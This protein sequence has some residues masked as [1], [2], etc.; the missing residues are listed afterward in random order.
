MDERTTIVRYGPPELSDGFAIVKHESGQC[1]CRINAAGQKPVYLHKT[2]WY[3]S[4]FYFQS[5]AQIIAAIT[6]LY[7]ADYVTPTIVDRAL[8]AGLHVGEHYWCCLRTDADDDRTNAPVEP[9]CGILHRVQCVDYPLDV[10]KLYR[11][12]GSPPCMFSDFAVVHRPCDIFI[13]KQEA[14]NHYVIKTAEYVRS[15]AFRLIGHCDCL[16]RFLQPAG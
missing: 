4:P 2:A 10:Y 5:V 16:I 14:S 15:V 1:C 13:T 7:G 3:A 12:D 8:L 9:W 6:E 11:D